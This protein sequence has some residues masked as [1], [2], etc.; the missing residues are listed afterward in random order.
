MCEDWVFLGKV[1]LE[2]KVHLDR[3]GVVFLEVVGKGGAQALLQ[4]ALLVFGSDVIELEVMLLGRRATV[5]VVAAE[6]R[7]VLQQ[8]DQ[9]MPG[10]YP[11]SF[12][13]P[14]KFAVFDLG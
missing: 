1:A 3:G 8:P 14:P 11:N 4:E 12:Y 6:G 9:L 13:A 10:R 2:K 7:R 5:A